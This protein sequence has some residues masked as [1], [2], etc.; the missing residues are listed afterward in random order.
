VVLADGANVIVHLSPSPVVAKVAGSTPAVR[1]AAAAFG[2]G[3]LLGTVAAGQARRLRRPVFVGSLAFLVQAAFVA[4]VP[5]VGSTLAV[6]AA[7]ACFGMM[8]GFGNVVTITAFQRW[9]PPSMMGRLVGLLMLTS[10]GVFPIS[11]ALA[12]LVVRDLGPAPFF[13]FAAATLAVATLAGLSQRIW[14][15]FGAV[16]TGT[17]AQTAPATGTEG[18]PA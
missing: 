4:V 8:N 17:D 1:D 15:D 12:A 6:A 13:L 5:Y 9:V 11:V 3:A 7:M 18:Q 16:N 10:F 2:G 14:R